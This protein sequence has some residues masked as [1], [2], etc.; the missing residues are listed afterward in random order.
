MSVRQTYQQHVMES[1]KYLTT[2]KPMAE[3]ADFWFPSSSLQKSFV[4][5]KHRETDLENRHVWLL[6]K[7]DANFQAE[8]Q[9]NAVDMDVDAEKDA[10]VVLPT[11]GRKYMTF[12]MSTLVAPSKV[13]LVKVPLVAL[14]PYLLRRCC[15]A[16]TRHTVCQVTAVTVLRSPPTTRLPH[17]YHKCTIHV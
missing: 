9:E 13:V 12:R 7:Q 11:G 14:Q 3:P 16:V 15:S 4:V 2:S 10:L 1:I 8:E 5:M 6:D 17:V